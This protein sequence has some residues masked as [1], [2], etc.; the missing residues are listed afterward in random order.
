MSVPVSYQLTI[1]PWSVDSANDPLT[2]LVEL[3]TTARLGDI[4]TTALIRR[5]TLHR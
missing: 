4:D 2:E 3:E 1:G 5:I